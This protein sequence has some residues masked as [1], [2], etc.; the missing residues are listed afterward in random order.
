MD[1]GLCCAGLLAELLAKPGPERRP[2]VKGQLGQG[3]RFPRRL[4]EKA[5]CLDVV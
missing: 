5:E 4:Q 3:N 1:L 2:S